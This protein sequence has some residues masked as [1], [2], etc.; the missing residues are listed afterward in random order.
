MRLRTSHN[1]FLL[2]L[3]D[4]YEGVITALETLAADDT[5]TLAFVKARLLDHE[6]KLKSEASTSTSEKVLHVQA[7]PTKWYSRNTWKEKWRVQNLRANKSGRTDGKHHQLQGNN[8]K[9]KFKLSNIKC[10]HCGRRNT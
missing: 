10:D 6:V 3:T 5:L 7:K 1:C 4:S 8:H 9:R 2:T